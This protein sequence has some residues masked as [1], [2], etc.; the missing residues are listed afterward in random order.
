MGSNNE[1]GNETDIKDKV[2]IE[3]T[4]ASKEA[5]FDWSTASK[6]IQWTLFLFTMLFITSRVIKGI[7]S[8]DEIKGVMTSKP[9][10]IWFFALLSYITTITV[11]VISNKNVKLNTVGEKRKV[12]GGWEVLNLLVYF[13]IVI[14]AYTFCISYMCMKVRRKPIQFGGAFD[15]MDKGTGSTEVDPSIQMIILIGI[16]MSLL[17]SFTNIFL[18]LKNK[19]DSEKDSVARSIYQAQLCVLILMILTLIF[20]ISLSFG[21]NYISWEQA[22]GIDSFNTAGGEL[23][24]VLLFLILLIGGGVMVNFGARTDSFFGL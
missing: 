11:K 9:K 12:S 14:L 3:E 24:K 7:P 19:E 20:L 1:N 16:I 4:T 2:S 10:A 6:M 18:Y 5:A 17:N 8:S 13:I 22:I 21:K 15:W 23:L